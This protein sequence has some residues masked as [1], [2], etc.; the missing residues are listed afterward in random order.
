M[1]FRVYSMFIL[2]FL[3]L[4]AIMPV[5]GQQIACEV[6]SYNEVSVEYARNVRLINLQNGDFLPPKSGFPNLSARNF[7]NIF[8]PQV[9]NPDST[10]LPRFPVAIICHGANTSRKTNNASLRSIATEFAKR[11]FIAAIIDYRIDNEAIYHNANNILQFDHVSRALEFDSLKKCDQTYHLAYL[12]RMLYSNG[13][14]I[15]L[16]IN[17]FLREHQTYHVD[18]SRFIIGGH[19]LGGA[20][21]LAF[22]YFDKED[23]A[24]FFPG[25]FFTDS[26]YVDLKNYAPL[27]RSV[28]SLSGAMTSLEYVK[29]TENTPVFLFHGTHDAAA[30]FYSGTQFCSM[31]G[32]APIFFG[33]AALAEKLDRFDKSRSFSYYFVQANGIGHNPFIP[34]SFLQNEFP[35]HLWA[36]DLFRFIF[37]NVYFNNTRNRVHKILTPINDT[38]NYCTEQLLASDD[39]TAYSFYN[40]NKYYSDLNDTT[41]C[42]VLRGACMHIPQLNLSADNWIDSLDIH[43]EHLVPQINWN[44]Y[45]FETCDLEITPVILTDTKQEIINSAD[46]LLYPNP[47][48]NTIKIYAKDALITRVI[49]FS[50]SSATI[51]RFNQ[52]NRYEIFEIPVAALSRGLYFVQIETGDAMTMKK[53]VLQ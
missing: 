39:T 2:I 28:F 44:T 8:I 40:V 49:L 43:C 4:L 6:V 38:Y 15:H 9:A 14:D 48:G 13:L 34:N 50:A 32:N 26:R 17:F 1:L 3:A 5:Y 33:G 11:G 20:S 30:P 47:A 18:T 10:S 23:I 46:I 19:S 53:L 41:S 52:I 51:L 31:L 29:E 24:G 42:G 45:S 36:A 7:M 35:K 21:T 37:N 12:N 22:T 16:A 27:V 25:T